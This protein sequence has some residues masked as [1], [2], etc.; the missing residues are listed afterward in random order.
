MV[1]GVGM[2]IA[3]RNQNKG[4]ETFELMYMK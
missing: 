4:T 2:E 1:T 3:M